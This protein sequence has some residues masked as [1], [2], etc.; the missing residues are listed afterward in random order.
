MF[1]AIN[2]PWLVSPTSLLQNVSNSANWMPLFIVSRDNFFVIDDG[3]PTSLHV[4]VVELPRQKS[5]EAIHSYRYR[6]FF[7][8]QLW[9]VGQMQR[10]AGFDTSLNLGGRLFNSWQEFSWTDW[11]SVREIWL[12]VTVTGK[13]LATCFRS[14][15]L[16]QSHQGWIGSKN[17][18]TKQHGLKLYWF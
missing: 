16:V 8:L 2:H 10:L 17:K 14:I 9:Y 1:N 7:R 4:W 18:T 6:I 12:L 5:L 13:Q 11:I 3:D 15:V